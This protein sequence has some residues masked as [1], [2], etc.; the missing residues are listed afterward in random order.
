[1]P[2]ST[3]LTMLCLLSRDR[4]C[5]FLDILGLGDR[6]RWEWTVDFRTICLTR[7]PCGPTGR[8]ASLQAA[9]SGTRNYPAIHPSFCA[10]CRKGGWF[11]VTQAIG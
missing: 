4:A 6:D 7:S 2:L 11:C 1:M 5:R 8:G 9:R 10:R 3:S